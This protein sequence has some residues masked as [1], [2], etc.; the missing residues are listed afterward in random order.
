MTRFRIPPAHDL[1]MIIGVDQAD[2]VRL[3]RRY[4]SRGAGPFSYDPARAAAPFALDQ[5]LG[6]D[7]L[8]RQCNLTLPPDGR[9]PNCQIIRSL[10][11]LGG[12]KRW[13][14]Y[15]PPRWQLNFRSDLAV[16][17]RADRLVVEGERPYLLWMQMRTGQTAPS[18]VELALLGR[19]FMIQAARAGYSDVGLLIA[20]MRGVSGEERELRL[21][22]VADIRL[23][24]EAEAERKLQMFADAHDLLIKEGFDPKAERMARRRRRDGEPPQAS[25][26]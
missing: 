14:T 26:F 16:S 7:F 9:L 12:V 13:I 15:E 22:S 17:I 5:S 2:T 24:P 19:L 8:L 18:V 4:L 20:D 25:L 1:P 6:L 10:W 3:Y 23:V 21:T 11:R